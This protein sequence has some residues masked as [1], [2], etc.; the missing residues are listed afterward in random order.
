MN[1]RSLIIIS[2]LI[3]SNIQSQ[4]ITPSVFKLYDEVTT[5]NISA[6]GIGNLGFDSDINSYNP[7]YFAVDNSLSL[8]VLGSS[9][10]SSFRKFN[11]FNEETTNF[12]VGKLTVKPNLSIQYKTSDWAIGFNYI[13]TVLFN[14]LLSD[15]SVHLGTESGTYGWSLNNSKLKITNDILQF[16]ISR[17]LSDNFS[18]SVSLLTNNFNYLFRP[19]P[20]GSAGNNDFEFYNKAFS[21]VQYLFAINYYTPKEFSAYIIFKSQNKQLPLEPNKFLLENSI[22]VSNYSKVN[23]PANIGYGLQFKQIRSLKLSFEM[24]HQLFFE[25][26]IIKVRN[27]T[28][29]V[30]A[31]CNFFDNLLFGILFLYPIKYESSITMDEAGRTVFEDYITA[32]PDNRFSCILSS[33][34]KYD[35][36]K[37]LFAYQYSQVGSKGAY[38]EFKDL[39]HLILLGLRYDV[40]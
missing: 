30:G 6:Y 2:F 24:Y 37:L 7:N 23:F 39:S 29:N 11:Q 22:T 9:S 1:I 20:D 25:E 32:K 27:T 10:L 5:S 8:T 13:N 3:Y 16:S 28:I 26:N 40:L 18:A 35:K 33:S 15:F 12:S 14:R 17:K 19:F 38:S 4:S 36:F 31:N 34:Y 21:N